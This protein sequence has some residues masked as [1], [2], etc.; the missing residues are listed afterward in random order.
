MGSYKSVITTIPSGVVSVT[1]TDGTSYNTILNSQSGYV[2]G[3]LETY[4]HTLNVDQLFQPYLYNR[5]DVNGNIESYTENVLID[6]YQIINARVYKPLKDNVYFDGRTSMAFTILPN[7]I[8]NLLI[9][10]LQ[11]ANADMVTPTHF[12]NDDFF[13]VLNDYNQEL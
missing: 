7:E 3:L 4:I 6:P 5:Y 11:I 12:Y 1:S 13:N 8:I 2:Y 9:Y 10:V